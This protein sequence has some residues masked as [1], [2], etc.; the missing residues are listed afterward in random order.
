MAATNGD[1]LR[2][3]DTQ[4]YLGETCLNVYYYRVNSIVGLDA[5]YLTA[6]NTIWEEVVMTPITAL[7]GSNLL[8]TAREWRNLS[9][10]VDISVITSVV[11]GQVS[12]SSSAPS[13]TSYG[14]MLVRESLVTRNGY[15]RFAGIPDSFIDGNN[16]VEDPT[17]ITDVE[18]GLASDL[19]LGLIGVAAP[20]IV[21]R[22]IDTPAGEYVYSDIGSAAFRGIGTQNTRKQNRGI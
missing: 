18:N 22:P 1:L 11:P 16:Y 20:V 8:H 9:N 6:M 4:S 19:T 5:D 3:V 17:W 14:F 10:G 7:Q 2:C 15:K 21:K 12:E 13:F